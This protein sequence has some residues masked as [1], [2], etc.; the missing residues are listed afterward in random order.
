[1]I[2]RS[3]MHTKPK[4]NIAI[5]CAEDAIGTIP[6]HLLDKGLQRPRNYEWYSKRAKHEAEAGTT[7]AG[8]LDLIDVYQ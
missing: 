1:M 7:A 5:F 8:D 6:Q 2:Y 3:R 4:R